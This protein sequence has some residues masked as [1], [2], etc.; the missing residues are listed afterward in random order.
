MSYPSDSSVPSR[1]TASPDGTFSIG[2]DAWLARMGNLRNV[3]RQEL[4]TRQLAAHLPPPPARILDVGAG[5][6]TQAIRLAARGYLVTAVE[7]DA[8]MRELFTAAAG[9]QPDDVQ[10]RIDLRA[11]RI[12][13][14]AAALGNGSDATYD[15]VLC[16]GV[17]MYLPSA[18]SAITELA[19]FV[20][21]DGFLAVAARSAAF[22]PWRPLLRSDWQGAQDAF[23]ELDLAAAQARD[24]RYVNEIGSPARADTIDG[25]ITLCQAAGLHCESWYGVRV[26]S[27]DEDLAAPVPADEAELA[28]ILQ[29]EERLGRTDPYRQLGA[30]FHLIA[31][32]P[33]LGTR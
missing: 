27:D 21:A 31:R 17:L 4:I 24:A 12:G 28:R 30:L 5:Q 14:L 32:R 16:H 23:D 15:A 7:P 18:D 8:Q 19:G 9:R 25:L 3:V 1:G 10:A 2:K 22:L 29:I 6:G 13:E 20:A 26:A 33:R 11:G